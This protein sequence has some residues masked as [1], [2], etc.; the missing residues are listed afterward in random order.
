MNILRGIFPRTHNKEN[1]DSVQDILLVLY[2]LNEAGER[3]SGSSVLMAKIK[4]LKLVFLSEKE[5]VDGRLKGFNFFFNVYKHGPSSIE[6]LNMIDHLSDQKLITYQERTFCI[7][8]KGKELISE[9]IFS[10]TDNTAFF[11]VIDNIL[12]QYGDLSPEKIIEKVYAMEMKPM[13]SDEQINIGEA[14]KTSA[15]KRLLMKLD[16]SEAAK[17]LN[18]PDDWIETVNFSMNP[19]FV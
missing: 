11:N 7:T 9:F 3:I 5:M 15:R 19:E 4:L 2:L 18:V 17:E 14:V 16:S 1:K 13:H 8:E 12:T 6:L 10:V